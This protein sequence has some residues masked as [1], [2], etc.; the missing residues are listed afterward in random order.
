MTR[1]EVKI[2]IEVLALYKRELEQ[3]I[4]RRTGDDWIGKLP[5]ESQIV[6]DLYDKSQTVIYGK[7]LIRMPKNCD[8][9]N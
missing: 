2:I 8:K 1:G 9:D 4:T 7:P 6:A 3:D 5:Y